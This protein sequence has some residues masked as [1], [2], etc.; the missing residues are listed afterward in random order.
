MS[1]IEHQSFRKQG[2]RMEEKETDKKEDDDEEEKEEG[3]VMGHD[4][5]EIK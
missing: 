5:E 3:K 2:Q 4:D 1:E